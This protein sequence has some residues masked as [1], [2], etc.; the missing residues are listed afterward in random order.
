ME[1]VNVLC[2]K[3]FCD[4]NFSVNHIHVFTVKPV[5]KGHSR[6]AENV[7][8]IYRFKLYLLFINE[9]HEVTIL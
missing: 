4:M 1:C 2:A 3:M 5:Y 6:E 9:K 8:F 7:L